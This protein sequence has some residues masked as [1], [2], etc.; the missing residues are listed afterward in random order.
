[1][2]YLT[3]HIAKRPANEK[4]EKQQQQRTN[5]QLDNYH[6][7]CCCFVQ[8]K[9]AVTQLYIIQ[10]IFSLLLLETKYFQISLQLKSHNLAGK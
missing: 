10:C 7:H 6:Y 4:H 1:M 3:N 2:D 8:C 9:T 5:K